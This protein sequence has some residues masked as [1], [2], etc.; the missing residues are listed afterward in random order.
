MNDWDAAIRDLPANI[1]GAILRDVPMSR[2]TTL[3]V[4]GVADYLYTACDVESLAALIIAAQRRGLA[5]HLLGDGSNVC[6]SDSGVRGMVICNG[7]SYVEMGVRTTVDTGH[8]FMQLSLLA[9]QSGLSGLEW[10]VGI[11][12]TVGGALVSNAGAYG[13]NIVDIVESMEVVENAE[14][15]TVRP[16][17]MEFSYRDSRLRR[18]TTRPAALLRT[19]LRLTPEPKPVIRQRAKEIQRQRMLKQPWEPSAGSFFKNIHNRELA[20]SIAGLPDLMKERGVVTSAFLIDKSGCKGLRVGGA[21]V[22]LKHANFVVNFGHATASEIRSVVETVRARVRT[23]F[24]IELEE[25][26]LYVGDWSHAPNSG[27]QTPH[28]I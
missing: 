21:G 18:D 7:C 17:W 12:G 10:A 26:V 14:R 4:G 20:Q 5:H 15:K 3:R 1:R 6:V 25:E 27:C 22:S 9:V 13:G 19:V 8:N 28:L 11:P 2:Y 23:S 24:G 16:E